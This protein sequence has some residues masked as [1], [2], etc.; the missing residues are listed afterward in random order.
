MKSS[1]EIWVAVNKNGSVRMFTEE[2]IRNNETGLW[3][4]KPFVNCVLQSQFE[5]LINKSEITWEMDPN[6]FTI[7]L[8]KNA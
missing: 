8:G 6:P 4:G 3:E 7:N 1:I 5:E 2:P